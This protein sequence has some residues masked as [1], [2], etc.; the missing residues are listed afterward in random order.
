V[1]NPAPFPGTKR[2]PNGTSRPGPNLY[3]NTLIAADAR[4]GKVLWYYQAVPHDFRDHD[5]QLPPVLATF[6]VNGAPTDVVVVSGK[7]GTVYVVDRA[8]GRL[9]WKRD[10]GR[11]NKWGDP[12]QKFPLNAKVTMYPGIYGGVETPMAVSDG[13]IYAPVNNTC[14]RITNRVQLE[15]CDA[16]K[17]T[18]ELVALDGATGR[19]LW[20]RDFPSNV[21]GGATVVNGLVVT[22]TYNRRV[23]ALNRTTGQV[24]WQQQT[25][26]GI[27]AT[28]AVTQNEIFL[29]AGS[30][31]TKAQRALLY[32]W[33]LP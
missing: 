29:G 9:I 23:Y 28:P 30:V 6:N 17:G 32:A 8:R 12:A 27:N 13:V 16:T 7:M 18:G 5:L 15:S 25:S 11:H 1:A 33:R 31:A 14:A 26:A 22:S 2:F 4:T 24:V 10:V 19:Q 3:T 21:Y 20:K